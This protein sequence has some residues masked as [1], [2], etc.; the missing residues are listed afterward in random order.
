MK[1]WWIDPVYGNDINTG[2]SKAQAKQTFMGESGLTTVLDF[3]DMN[4]IHLALAQYDESMTIDLSYF[5][6]TLCGA[7]FLPIM[8]YP[9]FMNSSGG[10]GA[11]LSV[12]ENSILDGIFVVVL[13]DQT[14]IS[15]DGA[16]LE[17]NNIGI[18]VA[19]ARATGLYVGSG[20]VTKTRS[21]MIL[22][23][24]STDLSNSY[25]VEL[26]SSSMPFYMTDIMF[27]FDPNDPTYP[28]PETNLWKD[29][30]SVGVA[31][32][33]YNNI[34]AS[35]DFYTGEV[36]LL[37]E[38]D[39][40]PSGATLKDPRPVE[41]FGGHD[42][43]SKIVL[44]NRNVA[45]GSVVAQGGTSDKTNTEIYS[46]VTAIVVGP[47]IYNN[48]KA[49]LD[50]PFSGTKTFPMFLMIFDGKGAPLDPDSVPTIAISSSDG[51]PRIPETNMIYVSK[52]QYVYNYVL[53]PSSPLETEE[54]LM[55]IVI[56][57]ITIPRP[58]LTE[59][60]EEIN[61][62]FVGEQL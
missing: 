38:P 35:T 11:I 18:I 14:G 59:V 58:S 1:H 50:R 13:D 39:M 52:G 56:G 44:A 36:M 10:S 7:E 54:V 31:I 41:G 29:D 21:V 32:R 48:V 45:D 19:G 34:Y 12:S 61:T 20:L 24:P 43:L 37:T 57:G 2:D 51:T 55:K 28:F 47:Q 62:G 60:Y 53:N 4:V 25:L 17:L 30:I 26:A 33:P 3:N 27:L 40:H 6:V 42:L 15:F 16:S 5:S 8:A 22:P 49:N 46:A 9:G 23:Y